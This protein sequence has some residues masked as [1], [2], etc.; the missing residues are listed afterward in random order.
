MLDEIGVPVLVLK[1]TMVMLDKVG[2]LV[3]VLMPV[4]I[5]LDVVGVSSPSMLHVPLSVL[6]LLKKLVISILR[7]GSLT[8]IVLKLSSNIPHSM[9]TSSKWEQS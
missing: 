5:V 4:V 8:F 1:P 9:V 6:G 2:V 7:S 3:L